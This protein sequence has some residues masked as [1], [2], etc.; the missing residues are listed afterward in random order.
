MG[1]TVNVG[2]L[3]RAIRAVVAA[4]LLY[5]ALFFPDIS[6]DSVSSAL[7]LLAGALLI[8]VALA[9]YCPIYKLL[10]IDTSSHPGRTQQ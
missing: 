6:N 10:A 5:L 1:F 8:A 2:R 7:L 9:G 4:V 3:D